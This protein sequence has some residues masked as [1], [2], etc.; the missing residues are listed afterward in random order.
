MKKIVVGSVEKGAGK[1]SMI[2]GLSKAFSK[3]MGYMKPLGD[4]LLYK[5]KRLWD[6]DSA[7]ITNTFNLSEAPEDMSIG[8]EHVKLKFMYNKDDV[9]KR[10]S[11]DSERN[12]KGKDVLFIEGPENMF[13]GASLNLDT[14][15]ITKVLGAKLLLVLSGKE[16]NILDQVVFVGNRIDSSGVGIEGIIV[17]KVQDIDD[18]NNTYVPDIK[19]SGLNLLGVIPYHEELSL[20]SAGFLADALFAKVL[21]GESGLSRI[22]S[23]I[24]VGA[25]SAQTV[26]KGHIFDKEKRKLVITAGDRSDMILTALETGSSAIVLTNNV[27]P[28]TNIISRAEEMSVPLL[29]V[30]SDTYQAAKQIDDLEPLLMKGDTDKINLLV[31][32]V[33]KSIINFL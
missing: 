6:Y 16:E 13:R 28:E 18:F 3:S 17:N 19:K 29:L 30:S 33:E 32:E 27:L 31:K 23:K 14:L 4:R 20:F 25:A 24:F 15:E 2:T 1:T 8:F 7:F 10:L 26:V 22:I 9:V 12:G 5:K 21:A 11:E